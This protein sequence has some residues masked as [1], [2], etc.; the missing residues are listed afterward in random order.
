MDRQ[1]GLFIWLAASIFLLLSS[2][3]FLWIFLR[4]QHVKMRHFFIGTPGYLD[5]KYIGW[6]REHERGYL[7]TIIV[8]VVLAFSIILAVL[9]IQ[10]ALKGGA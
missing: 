9:F 5:F 4:R 8:R 10:N 3:A 7:I 1:G 6:C 2:Q